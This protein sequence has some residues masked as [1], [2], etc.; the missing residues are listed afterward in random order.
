MNIEQDQAVLIQ[1]ELLLSTARARIDS[2]EDAW[3]WIG[4]ALSRAQAL[5]LH[6]DI[7]QPQTDQTRRKL[8]RRIWWSCYIREQ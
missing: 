3:F 2:R 5:G 7:P 6:L 8:R 4:T 1:S